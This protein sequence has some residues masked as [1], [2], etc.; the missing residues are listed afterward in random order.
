ML[1]LDISCYGSKIFIVCLMEL[2]HQQAA[3]QDE[4]ESV[5]LVAALF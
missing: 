3:T 4:Y 1:T 2:D 5:Q